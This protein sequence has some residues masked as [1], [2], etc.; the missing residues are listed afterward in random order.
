MS[1]ESDIDENGRVIIGIGDS[2]N[3][4]ASALHRRHDTA[5]TTEHTEIRPYHGMRTGSPS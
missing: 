2:C 5:G 4:V 3:G 1:D